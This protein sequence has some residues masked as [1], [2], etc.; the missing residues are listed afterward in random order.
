[1]LFLLLLFNKSFHFSL[2]CEV[3]VKM[4]NAETEDNTVHR[5]QAIFFISDKVMI[6]NFKK[7]L[8]SESVYI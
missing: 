7:I 8:R 6:H 5:V 1:M 2:N 4:Y 3:L